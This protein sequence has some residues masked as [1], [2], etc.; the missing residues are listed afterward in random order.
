MTF[1]PRSPTAACRLLA[2]MIA[3]GGSA[4]A[5]DA[6]P[7]AQA[8]AKEHA[9]VVKPLLT[10]YCMDCHEGEDAKGNVRLD[11]LSAEVTDANEAR[12]TDVRN[13][14]DV[15]AMPPAARKERPSRAEQDQ[16][17]KW[18]ANA[19]DR[20]T[21]DEHETGGDTLIRRINHRAYA[22]IMRTLLGVPAQ[23]TDL[24][25][26]DG[27]SGGYDT[28]GDGLYATTYLYDR[29]LQ[30][31]QQ[32]LDHAIGTGPAPTPV[33]IAIHARDAAVD[34]LRGK[35]EMLSKTLAELAKHP[36]RKDMDNL[37]LNFRRALDSN[38][39]IGTIDRAI[40]DHYH[41][42][43]KASLYDFTLKRKDL[44]YLADPE[45]IDQAVIPAG[46]ALLEHLKAVIDSVPELQPYYSNGQGAG[47]FYGGNRAVTIKDPGY[48]RIQV[49]LCV[50]D[51]RV[52][53]PTL[54]LIDGRTVQRRMIY[55]PVSAPAQVSFSTYLQTGRY[56]IRL[57][58]FD[59]FQNFVDYV[60]ARTKS[61]FTR[62]DFLRPINYP[63]EPLKPTV[64][65]GDLRVDGPIIDG[66]PSPAATRIFTRG[67]GAPLT[68]DYARE[69][70]SAF[71]RR[72]CAGTSGEALSA[73][74]VDLIMKHFE[75]HHDAVAAVKFGLAAALS[76][77]TF[78]YL[79]EAR[80]EQP[81][82]R[83]PLGPF[84]LA[85]KLAYALWSDL[86]DEALLAS[87]SAGTLTDDAELKAQAHRLLADP[88]SASFRDGF[89]TQWLKIDHLDGIS[90]S[91]E[92][93]PSVDG[94]LV[95]SAREESVGFF[96][97]VLD[98]NLSIASFIDADFTV[99]NQ[100]LA[101]LYGIPG[102][103]GNEMRRVALPAGSHRGGI[104]GQA[105]VLMAT[106][107]GMV[108]SPVRRGAFIMERLLGVAPGVPPPNVPAIDKVPTTGPDGTLL[109]ARE[110]LAFHRA[111]PSCARCHD[112]IDPLGLGLEQYD[113]VGA[114]SEQLRLY[115]P[116]AGEKK[117]SWVEHAADLHGAL[118]DGTAC[119]GPEQLKQRLLEHRDQVTRC[120]TENL[121]VY[122]LGRKLELSDR[123]ELERICARCAQAKYGLGTLIEL[124]ITS[125]LFREK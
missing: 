17:L 8:L 72:A 82:R 84:E 19:L 57:Q 99:L 92:L 12:W 86:P 63:G 105:S 46:R 39:G 31:A 119:D 74:Y 90:F 7:T 32:T 44:D 88:R 79:D 10:T 47:D 113:A 37:M 78:L 11:Q 87:A 22:N 76:S 34:E 29:Y 13:V 112:R 9:A 97:Q 30:S 70:V 43:E 56:E 54:I 40:L 122:L 114:F 33:A 96:S 123:P 71:M 102:V 100:R 61:T 103:A 91:H 121:L 23:G 60:N 107:N 26:A 58:P 21:L 62:H 36:P 4:A 93:Y 59:N 117:A 108:S 5:L 104:L 110:R 77:P 51:E 35:C 1:A 3:I 67:A 2:L 38:L 25:A 55:E 66:W 52:P 98:A 118:L 116:A 48:Y 83:R 16:L 80:R 18:V 89:A 75:A 53:L 94:V 73:P 81:A 14:L 85:R 125:P 41:Q 65:W 111:N 115:R 69:I 6:P 24:F 15:G 109:T 28:V 50:T 49:T 42:D 101:E 106:S 68:R 27:R 124:I 20:H 95:A 64:L 45:C 120:L